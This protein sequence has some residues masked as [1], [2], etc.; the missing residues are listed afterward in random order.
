M[1]AAPILLMALLL[2][3]PARAAEGDLPHRTPGFY[4]GAGIGYS[5]LEL[6]NG[7]IQVSGGDFAYRLSA[8][9]RFP[10]AFL[11]WGINVAAEAA[12]VDLGEVDDNALG[13]RLGLAVDG[14]DGAIVAYVPLKRRVEAFGRLG[15]MLWDAEFTAD[16]AQRDRDD[17]TDLAWGVGVALQ[18]GGQLAAQ[19]EVQGYD[20]LDGALLGTVTVIYQFK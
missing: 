15:M 13:S 20:V 18:T 9:Y 4:V 19:L 8:G 7:P 1:R 17:G 10:A 3:A 12:W 2:S 11:P 6:D 14:F 5:D 16:G